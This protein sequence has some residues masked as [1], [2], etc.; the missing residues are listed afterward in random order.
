MSKKPKV[1][2]FRNPVY[3]VYILAGVALFLLSAEIANSGTS[4]LENSIFS[5][6]N[7]LHNWFFPVFFLT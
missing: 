6:V 4:N 2:I 5:S 7:G 3:I 1:V